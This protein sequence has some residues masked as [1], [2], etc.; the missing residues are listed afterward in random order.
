MFLAIV[1]ASSCCEKNE[2]ESKEEKK[3]ETTSMNSTKKPIL[4]IQSGVY[5]G[6]VESYLELRDYYL[7]S[8]SGDFLFWAMLMANKH[9]YGKAYLDV[10]Y[11]F[12]DYSGQ[13]KFSEMDTKTQEFLLF[14]LK[15]ASEKGESEADEILKSIK[16]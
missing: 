10:Y 2:P 14:Y 13:M 1:F 16:N 3:E 15:K 4:K 7:D 12:S 11:A 6:E 9:D 8:F 5:K